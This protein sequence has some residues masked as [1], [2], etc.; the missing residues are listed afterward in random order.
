MALAVL[1]EITFSD[2]ISTT[3]TDMN[4][5]WLKT[6]TEVSLSA[7][8]SSIICCGSGGGSILALFAAVLFEIT[9]SDA[10]SQSVMVLIYRTFLG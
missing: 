8:N 4:W 7:I 5:C 6:I 1:S 2:A 10:I 3:N 9:I